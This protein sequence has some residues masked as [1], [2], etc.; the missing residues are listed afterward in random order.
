MILE[1]GY[2]RTKNPVT[3]EYRPMTLD[4]AKALSYGDHVTIRAAD[5][6]ARTVKVNGNPKT[7]K[8]DATRVEVPVKYGMYEYATFRNL[9]NG[10][11]GNEIAQLVV[12]VQP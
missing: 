9:P 12:K 2:D 6:K 1:D 10:T 4:E 11:V 5:G 7:W 8:R 3:A